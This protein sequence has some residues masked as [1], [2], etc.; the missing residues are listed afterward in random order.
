MEMKIINNLK[1]VPADVVA[2]IIHEYDCAY[3]DI[4]YEISSECEA[5][6]YPSMGS[7]FELRLAEYDDYFSDLWVSLLAKYGYIY[8]SQDDYI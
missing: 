7:N 3:D 5:E 6:G 8:R 4:V 1:D 2:D